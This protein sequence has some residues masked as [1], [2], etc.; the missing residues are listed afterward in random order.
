MS[1]ARFLALTAVVAVSALSVVAPAQAAT[2]KPDSGTVFTPVSPTRI[3]DS[4]NSSKIPA[5][6][7]VAVSIPTDLVPA[8]ATAVVFNLTGTDPDGPTWLAE[9][10]GTHGTP[11]TS[12]LNLAGGE[13]RA[14]LVTVALGHGDNPGIWLAAGP[15]ATDAIVDVAGYYRPMGGSKFTSVAPQRILDTRN[16]APLGTGGTVTLDLSSLVPASATAVVFNL[17][18]TDVTGPTFVTA[19]P[20]GEARPDASNVNLVAGKDIPNLVT[21]RLGTDRKVSLTNAHF[22]TDVV[23]D[24]AGYYSTDSTQAFYPL[25]PGRVLDTR[26]GDGTPRDPLQS[27]ET[28]P[29]SLDRWLPYGATAAVVNMTA[30]NVTGNTVITVWA[31]GGPKPGVSNLNLLPGQ[32]SANAAVAPLSNGRA[33]DINNRQG[34]LDSIVDLAGYFAPAR[35][36]CTSACAV[37]SGANDVG[38]AGDGTTD[39]GSRVD[40]AVYGLSGVTAIANT[41]RNGYALL[42]DGT[43]WSWG[44]NDRGQLGVSYAGNGEGPLG[45]AY[46]SPLPTQFLGNIKQITPGMALTND[47]K[48]LTWGANESLQLGIGNPDTTWFQTGT[49]GVL[50]EVQAIAEYRNG[51]GG[52]TRYALKN[53][54]TVWAWG[55]NTNGA[56]GNHDVVG[57]SASPVQVYGLSGCSG[58]GARIALCPAGDG[59]QT[60]WRW[61]A[62][63]SGHQDSPAALPVPAGHI[64][65]VQRDNGPDQGARALMSDGTVWQ[66]PDGDGFTGTFQGAQVAGLSSIKALASGHA[67]AT[68]GTEWAFADL[69]APVRAGVSALGD[70]SYYVSAG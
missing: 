10:P 44:A 8:D 26:N 66:W 50:S 69:S 41:D 27:G 14:N 42:S 58:I 29:L 22:S 67:L 64:V 13:T 24:F 4:R 63:G 31:D 37:A 32:T 39:G 38:Q 62:L 1:V 59:T 68:D 19:Y 65:S 23:V 54:G 3:F 52:V 36:A 33:M 9:G 46:F 34:Q 17:T 48:V 18:G 55:D 15:F 47:G 49:T 40:S 2:A 25:L 30:T 45:E 28:R 60:V 7:Q 11:T 5:R 53:N 16:S 56:L 20:S 6:G 35:S 57:T 21:V 43:A 61:G 51:S 70:G 12:S